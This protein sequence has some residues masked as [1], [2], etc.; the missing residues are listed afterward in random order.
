M[1]QA[2][3][4]NVF[5]FSA[6][7][8]RAEIMA[9]SSA[10]RDEKGR[11]RSFA[12]FKREASQIV[13]EFQG[14]WLRTEYNLAINAGTMAARWV[15]HSADPNAILRYRTVGD[16]RVRPEHKLLDGICKYAIDPFWNIYYP[17]NGWECRCDAEKTTSGAV[18]G[19]DAIPHGAID[20]VPPM[21]RSNFAKNGW[22]FPPDHPYFLKQP[23]NAAEEKENERVRLAC[24]Q[25][26][27]IEALAG[28]EKVKRPE[29]PGEIEFTKKGLKEA[30]N[31]PHKNKSAKTTMLPHIKSVL[32]QAPY[33]GFTKYPADN[34]MIAGSHI[35]ETTLNGEKTWLIVR[36]HVDGK[37]IFYSV[38][39]SDKIADAIKRNKD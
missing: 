32:E 9:M 6:A 2:L 31:Q 11:L 30:F 34:P 12:E 28:K 33:A 16:A 5:H 24:Y 20:G 21:F 18:T 17:P 19:D 23:K 1:L 7:K 4:D 13:G 25:K 3:A 8:N 14:N 39:D 15:E 29:L 22:V 36:E 26:Q 10:L 35:F 37:F 27:A 38:S